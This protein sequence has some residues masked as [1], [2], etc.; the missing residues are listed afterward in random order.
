[1]WNLRNR[2]LIPILSVAILGLALVSAVSYTLA[3]KALSSSLLNDAK[4]SAKAL[5]G[6]IGMVIEGAQS[7][8]QLLAATAM[9]QDMLDREGGREAEPAMLQK[10]MKGL[11]AKK[12]YYQLIHVIDADGMVV[13]S[14]VDSPPKESLKGRS[15][16]APTMDGGSVY[17][18]EAIKSLTT[19]RTVLPVAVPVTIKG[20][21]AGIVLITVDLVTFSE[22]YV[23][24]I[25]LGSRGYAFV[26]TPEGNVPAHKDSAL[27][28]SDEVHKAQAVLQ[29]RNVT[30]GAGSFTATFN[31]AEAL[32]VYQREPLTG[33]FCVVRSDIDDVYSGVQALA[34]IS[35]GI[36]LGAALA[37]ALIVFLVVRAVVRALNQGVEFASAVARGSLDNTLAVRRGD[38]IGVLAD[39]LRT[40]VDNLKKMIS[41]AEQKTEEAR[42]Q[43]EKA[44]IAVGQAEEARA[45]AEQAMS[46]GMRRAGGELAGIV[47]RVDK[48]A[49]DLVVRV[50]QAAEGADTQLQRTSETATA[51]EE[52]NATVAEV[53]RNAGEAAGTADSAKQN[54]EEGARIVASVIEAI[55][56]VER[57]T[58]ELKDS[59]NALGEQAQD[60]GRVMGVISDIAD[61]TNLLALNAAIEA[62]RAGEAGRGFAVVADEV[63]KL[64]E[65]TMT[66]TKEVGDAVKAI[67]NGTEAN[68]HGMEDAAQSVARSTEMVQRAGDSLRS[69]VAVAES[70]ADKVQSIAAASEQQSAAGEEI[71][72]G[73][74]EI[75]RIADETTQLMG[76]AQIAM[77]ELAD[78]VSET[79]QLVGRLQAA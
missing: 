32:Y 68:I 56:E 27:I 29:F 49:E 60:I 53:A 8:A 65:K 12:P 64:A 62:A 72:R 5:S 46:R 55:A 76:Q 75:N 43:A 50:R 3:E 35:F 6:I 28:M 14:S 71:T 37:I 44:E 69:I 24:P 4:G 25:V 16:F 48:T 1:M 11:L 70:T 78:L 58:S 20:S 21:P 17:I 51:M 38:E 74:G 67:Q 61:Q 77:R 57:K 42:K 73:T 79:S 41:T 9:V 2:L 36:S 54:A 40:M 26:V 31:G 39:A 63:R 47:E 34:R 19:G 52:M 22:T 10:A 23:Q 18:G 45:E 13:G 59:L 7:D 33:W 30:D 15:Y 66:A